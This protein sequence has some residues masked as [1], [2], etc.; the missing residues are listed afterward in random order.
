MANTAPK[1]KN[2][3]FLFFFF[4]NFVQE[5]DETLVKTNGPKIKSSEYFVLAIWS[6]TQVKSTIHEY[7][8]V[9]PNIYT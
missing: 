7:V 2:D 5:T 4:K 3:F 1:S 8:C 6:H 9:C